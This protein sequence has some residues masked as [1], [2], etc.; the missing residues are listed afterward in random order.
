MRGGHLESRCLLEVLLDRRDEDAEGKS[1]E[2][3]LSG[4]G[5][6]IRCGMSW[7]AWHLIFVASRGKECSSP[8][9]SG[10]LNL[11]G[12][13]TFEFLITHEHHQDGF[14]QVI[15]VTNYTV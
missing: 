7:H 4:P 15:Y 3:I 10:S 13:E 9:F 14:T 6:S 1:N 2:N 5:L 11:R 12:V 8:E